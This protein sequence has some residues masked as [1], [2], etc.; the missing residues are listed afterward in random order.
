MGPLEEL[1]ERCDRA[2]E[3]KEDYPKSREVRAERKR[4]LEDYTNCYA[5]VIYEQTH[6]LVRVDKSK[7]VGLRDLRDIRNLL[8]AYQERLEHEVAVSGASGTSVSAVAMASASIEATFDNTMSQ[9]W[10][11]P[12]DV[13]DSTQKQEL[14]KLLQG[15]EDAKGSESKLKKAGKAVA[16]WLFDNAVKAVPTVMPYVVQTIQGTLG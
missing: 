9:M 11:L 13:L 15:I 10:G 8:R 7:H 2:L 6:S 3:S 12:D 14:A 4:I 16:D 5:R 1:I